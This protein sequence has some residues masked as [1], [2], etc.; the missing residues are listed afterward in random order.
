MN[1][2]PLGFFITW[3]CYGTWL[4]GDDRGWA[5]WQKGDQVPQPLLVDWCKEQ[6]TETPLVLNSAQREIVSAIVKDHCTKRGWT[7]HEVNCCSNHCHVVV[8]APNCGGEL[9]RD[10]LKAWGTRKLKE[11]DRSQGV[12]GEAVRDNWWTRKGSVRHLNDHESLEAAVIYVRD[13]QDV[14]GSN[15]GK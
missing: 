9:V 2:Q 13:A 3:T 1:E 4:P 8:T 15:Y 10:Q 6:M 7:L 12:A 14:G 11:N 5:R